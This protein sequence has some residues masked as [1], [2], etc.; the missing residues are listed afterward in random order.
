MGNSSS[1]VGLMSE[2][3][4]KYGYFSFMRG[5]SKKNKD[6]NQE[7]YK[8]KKQPH[9][10]TGCSNERSNNSET[11]NRDTN[12]CEEKFRTRFDPRITAR[13]I[14]LNSNFNDIC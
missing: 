9:L 6:F 11:R 5:Q 14:Q 1:K 7:F 3:P 12:K 10:W 8:Y 2:P 4:K 13:Y